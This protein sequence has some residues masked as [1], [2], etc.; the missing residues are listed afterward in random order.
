MSRH[1]WRTTSHITQSS[2]HMI[3]TCISTV[4]FA[5]GDK[6]SLQDGLVL[7]MRNW[8]YK[9]CVCIPGGKITRN[10]IT[11]CYSSVDDTSHDNESLAENKAT[12]DDYEDAVTAY[13]YWHKYL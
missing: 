8:K 4:S 1:Q 5:H 3:K 11:T 13:L 12:C 7:L 9:V 6:S 10:R 2:E